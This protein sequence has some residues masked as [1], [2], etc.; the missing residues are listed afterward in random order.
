MESRSS[1][2]LK[3]LLQLREMIL[4]G[5]L[6]P[7]ERVVEATLASRLDVSRTPLRTALMML[8]HEGLLHALPNGGFAVRDFSIKDIADA[9]DL[10]GVMEGTAARMA[11]ERGISRAEAAQMEAILAETEPLSRL[12]GDAAPEGFQRFI[13]LNARFHEH[14][15]VLADSGI[16][17]QA[18]AFAHALPFASPNA[19]LKVQAEFGENHEVRFLAQQHHRAILEA[20]VAREGARAEA[21]AREHARLAKRNL[22]LVLNNTDMLT[23]LPGGALIRLNMKKKERKRAN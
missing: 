15:L 13:T 4:S 17:R 12:S 2:K 7:G 21:V 22:D 8:E 16:L 18:M 10:R 11:A 5:D 23:A 9:I 3:A 20:I 19:F 6:Q 1:Q 14:L